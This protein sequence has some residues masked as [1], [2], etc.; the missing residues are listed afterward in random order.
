MLDSMMRCM[1]CM[2][3]TPDE[4]D[5][6]RGACMFNPPQIMTLPG[7]LQGT[8]VLK[9]MFPPVSADNGCGRWIQQGEGAV[10][11]GVVIGRPT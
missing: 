2:Y 3:F 9:A 4:K 11:G 8:L 1:R 10:A 7:K 5:Q 6:T